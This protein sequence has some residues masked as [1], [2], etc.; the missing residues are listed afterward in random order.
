MATSL[1]P[2]PDRDVLSDTQAMA[3]ALEQAG[4][5]ARSGEVPVG[6]VLLD[7]D[8]RL[9]SVGA[10]RTICDHDATQHA[11]IVALRAATAQAGN[12][13]LPGASLFVTLEP[14]MMCLGALLHARVA[15]VVW[16]AADPKTGVCG[17][18]ES[19]HLHPTL[20]HHTRVSGGLMAEECAQ[21]LRDFFRVRRAQQKAARGTPPEG[22]EHSG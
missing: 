5:A 19:L 4:R 18:V 1:T 20:N 12:Y 10:N 3:L 21:V 6:A 11:E 22:P 14:C 2:E 15:R 13:R 9:L 16:G 8:G 17:S 7:A